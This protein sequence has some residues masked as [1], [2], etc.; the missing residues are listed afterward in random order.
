MRI[1]NRLLTPVPSNSFTPV[2]QHGIP[3]QPVPVPAPQPQ[4]PNPMIPATSF[5][6]LPTPNPQ[7]VF[8]GNGT[9][10]TSGGNYAGPQPTPA[11]IPSN[12][13]QA[14]GALVAP[15]MPNMPIVRASGG[16]PGQD[17]HATP[18]D[19]EKFTG[20]VNIPPG[21]VEAWTS[22]L[23]IG[24]RMGADIVTGPFQPY[25]QPVI[26]PWDIGTSTLAATTTSLGNIVTVDGETFLGGF[27]GGQ[28]N[29]SGVYVNNPSRW[30]VRLGDRYY[31]AIEQD[32]SSSTLQG[33]GEEV[34]GDNLNHIAIFPSDSYISKTQNVSLDVRNEG[35]NAYVHKGLLLAYGRTPVEEDYMAMKW[36]SNPRFWVFRSGAFT[37]TAGPA[38]TTFSSPVRIFGIRMKAEPTAGSATTTAVRVK[39]RTSRRFDILKGFCVDQLL[40]GQYNQRTLVF[41]NP[42]Y[43]P[44]GGSIQV[45]WSNDLPNSP[46]AL[47]H[48]VVL[49]GQEAKG[50]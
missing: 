39:I 19:M 41:T 48:N 37:N 32:Q 38:V 12:Y 1:G 49:I 46:G 29:S 24:L 20:G 30:N 3:G 13:A 6:V 36:E 4:M 27:I 23:E 9:P 26:Y 22:I 45:S 35:G 33:V 43:L 21:M 17:E 16:Y 40:C 5:S 47:A 18:N 50:R 28:F 2:N 15:G 11:V 34:F 44:A 10:L 8:A 7:S 42:V 25:L 31:F 14:P